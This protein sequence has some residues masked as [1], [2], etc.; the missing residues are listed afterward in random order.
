MSL[1]SPLIPAPGIRP[2]G[3]VS[4]LLALAA[5]LLLAP[6]ALAVPS[7]SDQTGE[8]CSACHVGGFGPQL[9][10][11]GRAFKMT[12]YSDGQA[13]RVRPLLSGMAAFSFTHTKEGQDGGAAPGFDDNNNLA[14]DEVSLFLA[15]RIADHLGV[16]SQTTW[17]GVSHHFAWDNTDIRYGQELT[18]KGVDA[19]LG[20]SVN[21][22]PT[23][24]DPYNTTPVWG[25]PYASSGL[26]PGPAA[27]T[28]LEDGLGQKV[29]G[30][31]VY[32]LF[33]DTLYVE[34]G[35]YRR[36]GGG[37][38]DTLGVDINDG[39]VL[40]GFA[41]YGRVALQYEDLQHSAS[42]G[43]FGMAADIFPDNDRSEGSNR[44]RDIGFDASYQWHALKD[45]TISL[46]ASAIHE[47]RTMTASTAL[48]A[49]DQLKSHLNSYKLNGSY[50]FQQTYGLTLG[51]FRSDGTAD[52]TLYGSANGKPNSNGYIIQADWTPFGKKDSWMTPWAN[53]RLA[54]QYTGYTKF[55][56]ASTNYDGEG[57]NA[58]DNNTM[59]FLAWFA[60]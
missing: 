57:R 6:A 26:A 5:S 18:I 8:A 60:F 3:R 59:W 53:L 28:L 11:H 19:I 12:G 37:P 15:G 47:K 20:A 48:D 2:R 36:L 40:D 45:H 56:G 4:A 54:L 51:A 10:A 29:V 7:F 58:S 50:Y 52:A 23:I 24:S 16:F 42:V 43:L 41:P 17:D 13:N 21:N 31:T 55:D 49:A 22:S 25:F 44:Y 35:G 34:A 1:V 14:A 39:P 38:L 46:N 27:A 32:G 30:T 33:A 9:T